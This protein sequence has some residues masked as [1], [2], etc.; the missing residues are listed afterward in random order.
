MAI[1]ETF[2][3]FVDPV[4]IT[5]HDF[6]TEFAKV[7]EDYFTNSKIDKASKIREALGYK[8]GTIINPNNFNIKKL[9]EIEGLD[10]GLLDILKCIKPLSKDFTADMKIDAYANVIKL[11]MSHKF[12]DTDK[13]DVPS[14]L[15]VAAYGIAQESGNR[16]MFDKIKGIEGDSRDI[17]IKTKTLFGSTKYTKIVTSIINWFMG[18]DEKEKNSKYKTMFDK[19][20]ADAENAIMEAERIAALASKP[21]VS[22]KPSAPDAPVVRRPLPA[23]PESKPEVVASA[24]SV[25]PVDP[26]I[27]SKGRPLPVRPSVDV[28]PATIVPTTTVAPPL[29]SHAAPTSV[30]ETPTVDKTSAALTATGGNASLLAGIAGF[31][32]KKGESSLPEAGSAAAAPSNEVPTP[33]AETPAAGQVGASAASSID[34]STTSPSNPSNGAAIPA[35]EVGVG[36]PAGGPPRAPGSPPS[37]PPQRP[38]TAGPQHPPVQPSTADTSIAAPA[39]RRVV[40]PAVAVE[41]SALETPK[42]ITESKGKID[43]KFIA[44]YKMAA[45]LLN[46]DKVIPDLPDF[47]K[48]D[49]MPLQIASKGHGARLAALSAQYQKD[50]AVVDYVDGLFSLLRNCIGEYQKLILKPK[51]DPSKEESRSRLSGTFNIIKGLIAEYQAIIIRKKEEA[52]QTAALKP[53]AP[54]TAAAPRRPQPTTSVKPVVE[55]KIALGDILGLPLTIALKKTLKDL[56]AINGKIEAGQELIEADWDSLENALKNYNTQYENLKKAHNPQKPEFNIANQEI[57]GAYDKLAELLAKIKQ[58][59][60]GKEIEGLS[61]LIKKSEGLLKKEP[62]ITASSAAQASLPR[63]GEDHSSAVSLPNT[64]A[65]AVPPPNKSRVLGVSA[66]GLGTA[67]DISSSNLPPKPRPGGPSQRPRVPPGQQ[68][69]GKDPSPPTRIFGIKG[70]A[71]R[72]GSA[73]AAQKFT[74]PAA[75]TAGATEPA[76]I[77]T[78]VPTTTSSVPAQRSLIEEVNQKITARRY[79]FEHKDYTEDDNDDDS[80]FGDDESE[81]PISAI[82]TPPAKAVVTRPQAATVKTDTTP[83]PS[84][85][86]VGA[87]SLSPVI[88]TPASVVPTESSPLLAGGNRPAD[89]SAAFKTELMGIKDS[90]D[91]AQAAPVKADA[92]PGAAAAATVDV[93]AIAP[94]MAETTVSNTPSEVVDEFFKQFDAKIEAFTGDKFKGTRLDY[95]AF[96]EGIKANFKV[97]SD[98]NSLTAIESNIRFLEMAKRD[99]TGSDATLLSEIITAVKNT[100]VKES[101]QFFKSQMDIRDTLLQ[102]KS[103]SGDTPELDGPKT[104]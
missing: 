94:V 85:P 26:V 34:S 46:K 64:T 19:A 53:A 11:F 17:E 43:N 27:S 73:A 101:S 93:T 28:E 14:R 96:K 76:T 48:I 10:P 31:K 25:A 23:R 67:P 12:G 65:A 54:T 82:T 87:S 3:K 88:T 70:S 5:L 16:E 50:N 6:G 78:K 21:I 68:S 84:N 74:S 83:A 60:E 56:E 69:L 55:K 15:L 29:S 1:F 103:S 104:T 62:E 66:G 13:Y 102:I 45:H 100:F 75:E 20:R 38:P 97:P 49:D 35:P 7:L 79:L 61:A 47:P 51:G 99:A 52:A 42:E 22:A 98:D 72:P 77:A 8:P 32:F 39:L 37:G 71:T 59:S 44:W 24:S 9:E 95:E 4:A 41:Q 57:S 80:E 18:K 90:A 40:D 58:L 91:T 63:A 81:A 2:K 89:S 92:T 36:G 30:V 33:V 86:R